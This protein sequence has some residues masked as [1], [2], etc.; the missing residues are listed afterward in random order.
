MPKTAT[1]KVQRG[2]VAK[3]MLDNEKSML[4]DWKRMLDS[5]KTMLNDEKSMQLF[6]SVP[7]TLAPPTS[8]LKKKLAAF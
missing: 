6:S 4:D 1:G 5:E 3:R 7:Q 2:L 8:D